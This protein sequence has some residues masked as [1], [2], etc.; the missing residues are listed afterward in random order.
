MR[1]TIA[2]LEDNADRIVAMRDC[3]ADK[4]PTYELRVFQTAQEAVSWLRHHISRTICLSLDHDLEPQHPGDPDPGTGRD[5]VSFL[6]SVP[7]NCP[8]L[9]HTTNAPAGLAMDALLQESGWTTDRIMPYDGLSWIAQSW[10][11]AVRRLIVDSATAD[12]VASPMA[13][14]QR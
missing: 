13:G 7:A 10:L 2:I 8:V 14:L 11:P 1:L 4:F 6:V 12:P 3:L 5:V 9:I